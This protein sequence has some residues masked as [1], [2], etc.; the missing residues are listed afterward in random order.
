MWSSSAANLQSSAES[1]VL[2]AACTYSM[3][4][5]IDACSVE[6]EESERNIQLFW[7]FWGWSP[8]CT[9]FPCN[10]SCEYGRL[11]PSFSVQHTGIHATIIPMLHK[12][13]LHILQSRNAPRSKGS[14]VVKSLRSVAVWL[15]SAGVHF[16]H[17]ICLSLK[18]NV[19]WWV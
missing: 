12:F 18:S 19:N 5:W 10:W 14:Y 15:D 9:L 7:G 13:A 3:I 2:L 4:V 17:Y 11:H 1:A 8:N 6:V 16:V